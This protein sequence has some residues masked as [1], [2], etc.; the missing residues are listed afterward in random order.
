[1][2]L[3]S[4]GWGQL[5]RRKP[6]WAYLS[7]R[8]CLRQRGKGKYP[9]LFHPSTPHQGFRWPKAAKSHWMRTLGNAACKFKDQ[10][11]AAPWVEQKGK[12]R[13]WEQ[14]SNAGIRSR[15]LLSKQCCYERSWLCVPVHRFKIL[16]GVYPGAIGCVDL[17]FYRKPL[18]LLYVSH[19]Q[20]RWN[21]SWLWV[22]NNVEFQGSS[23]GSSELLS[24]PLMFPEADLNGLHLPGPLV[25]GWGSPVGST[26][27][28]AK[29]RWLLLPWTPLG[30]NNIFSPWLLH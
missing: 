8:S 9:G 22:P 3:G 19:S 5:E 10:P 14:T 13:N 23:I 4:L 30:E 2:A 11:P 1:M 28:R 6:R 17:T 18:K 21:L 24:L 26:G 16:G 12:D 20:L 25:S 27:E 15:V 29:R 7:R